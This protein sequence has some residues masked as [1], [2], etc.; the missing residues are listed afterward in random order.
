[1]QCA[2]RTLHGG[3]WYHLYGRAHRLVRALSHASLVGHLHPAA[4]HLRRVDDGGSNTWLPGH[5]GEEETYGVH[6]ATGFQQDMDVEGLRLGALRPHHDSVP[7]DPLQSI[8]S[9]ITYL[10]KSCP[11]GRPH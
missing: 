5:W 1:M 11:G 9:A 4:G 7:D 2:P 10:E 3:H 8:L 6:L